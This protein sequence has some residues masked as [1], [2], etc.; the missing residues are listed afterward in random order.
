MQ[1]LL[2]TLFAVLSLLLIAVPGYL[3]INRKMISEECIGG[4][5]KI[6]LYV[7]QPCL[8]VYTFTEAEFSLKVLA[9][10]GIFALISLLLVSAMLCG[11]YL[12]LR[13]KYADPIHRIMT[14]AVA[15]ANCAFFG[16]P[17]IEALLPDK[18]AGLMIYTTVFAVVMNIIGWTLGSAIISGNAKHVSVKKIFLNPAVIGLLVA[19]FI[20]ILRIPIQKD[21]LSMIS[22]TG[23]MCSPLSMLIMGMRLATMKPSDIFTNPRVYL[24][25]A[26]KQMLMPLV[27][28]AIIFF[29]PL[30]PEVKQTFFII[31]ACPVASVVL[32]FAEIVGAGQKE[33]A[34][35]V[36]VGTMLSIVTMPVMMLMLPLL[37]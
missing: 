19:M 6:L 10:I 35:M 25:I 22:V 30:A 16:I 8:A 4:A 28:F 1:I 3:L 14:V 24:T 37:A 12:I 18:A 26:V 7:A 20:F 33:G 29:M 23:R 15:F 36:L 13:K 31:A 11:A 9:D 2:I 27:A 5:S 17:V 21:I 34:A 32:N